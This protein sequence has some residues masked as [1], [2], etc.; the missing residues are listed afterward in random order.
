MKK[1]G[2]FKVGYDFSNNKDLSCLVV[3]EKKGR[4]YSII[5]TFYGKEEEDLYKTLTEKGEVNKEAD[6]ETD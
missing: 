3:I 2:Y 1:S 4:G 5:N 6:N